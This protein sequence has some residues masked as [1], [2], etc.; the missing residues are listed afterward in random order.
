MQAKLSGDLL[1]ASG[2]IGDTPR[3][4]QELLVVVSPF[5]R[6]IM[7]SIEGKQQRLEARRRKKQS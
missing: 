2:L 5:T 6:T 1:R 4:Q 3:H 7:T